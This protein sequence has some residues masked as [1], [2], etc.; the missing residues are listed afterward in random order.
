MGAVFLAED[1]RDGARVALKVLDRAVV[2]RDP[3]GLERFGREALAGSRIDSPHVVRVLDSGVEAD[4]P[5]LSMELVE[6]DA[7]DGWIARSG[8]LRGEA[9]WAILEPLFRAVAA[10]H[11]IGIVH[12]DLKPEHVM[13]T[14]RDGGPF[15]RVL[16]FGIAKQ[17]TDELGKSTAEGLGT[18]IWTAPE[19]SHRTRDLGKQAD[20]W[21]LGLLAFYVFTGRF[22]WRTANDE[23]ASPMDLILEL[24]RGDL[25]PASRRSQ[26]IG[27]PQLPSGFDAWFSRC[28]HRDPKARFADAG[29]A[30]EELARLLRPK[31]RAAVWLA[32]SVTI[33]VAVAV[34]AFA[35]RR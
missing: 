23:K 16:D 5:W 32:L 33:A 18:P 13:I 28:V 24:M 3:K 26:A 9:A 10:A 17:V 11:A 2:G 21:A 14:Q 12:R 22:Y 30:H 34:A 7:L 20:V 29:V 31:K 15:V 25:E 35:L 27:A 19:Q 4:T 8:P 6:G 1:G